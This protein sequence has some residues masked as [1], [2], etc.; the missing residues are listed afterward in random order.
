MTDSDSH[1]ELDTYLH[2]LTSH[3]G[4]DY[5][6][7]KTNARETFNEN[8]LGHLCE[9]LLGHRNN[10]GWWA[11][12]AHILSMSTTIAPWLWLKGITTHYIGSSYDPSTKIFDSNN[13][14]LIDA[15]QYDFCHFS[16][17]DAQ[18]NRNEKAAKIIT[19]RK[20]TNAPLQ[21][22]V[23][24]QR[25]AGINCSQCEKCYRTILNLISNRD[26]PNL[27]GF[28]VNRN[29]IQNM[30]QFVATNIVNSA[31][32]YPIQQ[33]MK[34]QRSFWENTEMAW[35]LD[36]QLNSPMVYCH[37]IMQKLRTICNV[38]HFHKR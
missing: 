27:Y 13:T 30:K 31:F 26:D 37:R 24:W 8:A 12:I 35:F 14:N 22:K 28:V 29:T 18:M 9:S 15:L 2:N 38:Q 20:M 3:L 32:W 17:V 33:R 23:C 36:M 25:T 16:S 21:L 5:C 4:L 6:F 10:H 1:A 19:Y 7:I 34:S 11:S